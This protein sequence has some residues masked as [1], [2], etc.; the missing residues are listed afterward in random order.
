M[1]LSGG[2]IAF[3][4]AAADLHGCSDLF[5]LHVVIVAHDQDL[6]LIERKLL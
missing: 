6:L 5:E 1:F 3:D 2:N 4:A